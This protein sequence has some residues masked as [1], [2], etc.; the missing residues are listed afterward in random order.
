MP[1]VKVVD[2]YRIA[3]KTLEELPAK[4]LKSKSGQRV[5]THEVAAILRTVLHWCHPELTTQD[6]QK[7]TRCE[8][9]EHYHRYKKKDESFRPQVVYMCSLT[10]TRRS[11][12]F[13]CRDGVEK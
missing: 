7:V 2:A 12:D 9:C 8:N 6:I 3:I 11:P 1:Q 10:K 4:S 5:N 13:F